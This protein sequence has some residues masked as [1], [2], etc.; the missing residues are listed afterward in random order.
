MLENAKAAGI[1]ISYDDIMKEI[2]EEEAYVESEAAQ[3]NELMIQRQKEDEELLAALGMTKD[4]FN[5]EVYADMLI[6]SKTFLEYGKYYY[7]NNIS[8]ATFEEYINQEFSKANVMIVKF[9]N[10]K[11]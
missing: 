4:E 7:M 2:R 5:Q 11:K 10:V 1:N 9:D 6:Y 3:G 8:S